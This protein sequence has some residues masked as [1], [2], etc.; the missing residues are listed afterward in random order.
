MALITLVDKILT[1][2][3]NG[4][5]VIG[6]FLDL[7]KA[8]VTV[9]HEILLKNYINMESEVW[10]I[11]GLNRISIIGHNLYTI[12][13]VPLTNLSFPVKCLKAPF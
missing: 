4:E 12:I 7:R 6:V 9:N 1:A 13:I 3:N 11:I 10:H 2:I 8:F 5:Y